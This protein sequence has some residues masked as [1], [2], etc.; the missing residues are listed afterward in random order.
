MMRASCSLER[1]A[2]LIITRG[3]PGSGKTTWAMSQTGFI[4]VNRDDLRQAL[5]GKPA[6]LTFEEEAEVTKA[7]RAQVESL[8]R[9][10][11]N[12]IVDDTNLNLRYAKDLADIATK[13]G[14]EF[15][16]KDF[17]VAPDLCVSRDTL[18]GMAGARKV[19][20]DVIGDMA[21][22]YPIKSWKPVVTRVH[23]TPTFEKWESEPG[24]PYA[25]LTDIDGTVADH[26]GIR[27]P[28]DYSK[29]H[30][31]RRKLHVTESIRAQARHSGMPIIALSGRDDSCYE[32]TF[33]WL[34]QVA[35]LDIAELHMR[36]TG[37]KR[38]DDIVKYEIFT[39]KIAPRFNV[40]TIYDDRLQVCRMW[41][42]I[43]LPLLRVGDPDADF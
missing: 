18:R 32:E 5:F 11:V 35:G 15:E 16:C 39:E 41:H 34:N 31:D 40:A 28:Y 27:S 25:I 23:P 36:K 7:Q 20:A 8:L 26:E 38:R 2:K 24:R 14:A 17:R 3:Y 13:A 29:V 6:P 30:L 12:V 4:R 33:D 19:G 43:G 37:D 42:S 21:K 10:N 1:V 9:A 22:R